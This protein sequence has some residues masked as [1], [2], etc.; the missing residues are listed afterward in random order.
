MCLGR[1]ASWHA[2]LS[3]ENFEG[4][5]PSKLQ[6]KTILTV[7]STMVS[8]EPNTEATIAKGTST[9]TIGLGLANM[10]KNEEIGAE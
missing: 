10:T 8:R 7:A 3:C 2:L 9:A 6:A 4:T 1:M 5:S